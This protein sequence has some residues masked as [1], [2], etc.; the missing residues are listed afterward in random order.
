M[1]EMTAVTALEGLIETVAGRHESAAVKSD[2]ALVGSAV[3]LLTKALL[4]R[5]DPSINLSAMDAGLAKAFD[6]ISDTI[7]AIEG[8]IAQP[9]P[10]RDA[11][12]SGA[13]AE[14]PQA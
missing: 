10:A 4:P 1:D 9:A 3:S 12:A 11:T 8:S 14:T 13:P 6:G 5:L 7:R 2:L